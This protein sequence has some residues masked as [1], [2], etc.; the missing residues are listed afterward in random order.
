MRSMPPRCSN[1]RWCRFVMV[2]FIRTAMGTMVLFGWVLSSWALAETLDSFD[3]LGHDFTEMV[4]PI[5]ESHCIT[6]HDA[7]VMEADLDLSRFASLD[8]VRHEPRVWQKVLRM[9]DDGQMPPKESR[10]LSEAQF[11]ELRGWI[12]SYLDAE[13]HAGAGDPGR[14]VVRR[15]NNVE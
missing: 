13:A 1:E 4:S 2:R 15:L 3:K 10:P 12:R 6:C 9:L 14:V 5:L 11:Q 8:D 7:E